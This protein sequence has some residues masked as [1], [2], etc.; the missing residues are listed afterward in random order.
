VARPL[1][2][3]FQGALYHVT[4]R[5]N[6]R[7]VIFSD[8]A[9]PLLFLGTLGSAV[10]NYSWL[11]HAYCLMPNHYHLLIETREPTLSRGMRQLNGVFAQAHNRRQGRS[12]HLFQGRFHAVL[13]EKEA[14]LL[15]VARYVVLNPCR[16]NLCVAPEE[17]LW[18]SYRPTAGLDRSPPFLATDWLLKQFGRDRARARQR[19]REFVAA[20]LPSDPWTRLRGQIF[21]GSDEFIRKY[22]PGGERPRGV[23]KRSNSRSDPVWWRLFT[24]TA[25]APSP[26]RGTMATQSRRSLTNS[27][28]TV[29]P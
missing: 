16:A 29:R 28:W 5:G 14:H 21:L 10:E 1:R 17:W 25:S 6:D 13:I 4:S 18:S 3:E 7:R 2:I 27:G 23:P 26:P 15:E 24:S 9:D 20:P 19:Y 12:G 22:S 11:C 8:D